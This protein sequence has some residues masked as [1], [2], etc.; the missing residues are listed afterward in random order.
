MLK[1]IVSFV[2][3]V[4]ARILRGDVRIA[5]I[6][7]G[8]DRG[9]RFGKGDGAVIRCDR[10]GGAGDGDRRQQSAKFQTLPPL[11]PIFLSIA[12][13]NLL[14]TDPAEMIGN[15]INMVDRGTAIKSSNGP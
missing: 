2:P 3:N 8:V 10:I 1:S 12:W 9:D 13:N 14:V 6:V 4:L 7:S 15:T 11:P 5:Q